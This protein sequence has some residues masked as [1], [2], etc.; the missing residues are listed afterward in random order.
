L[1]FVALLA[2][3]ELATDAGS[4]AVRLAYLA[5]LVVAGV[6]MID[7]IILERIRTIAFASLASFFLRVGTLTSASA[8]VTGAGVIGALFAVKMMT[9]FVGVRPTSTYFRL[10]KRER[11]Y[12][13]LLTATGLTFG[14]IAAL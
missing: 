13:T 11:T 10:P 2:L 12:T 1:I 6:F 8:L 7:R 9:K 3:G 4:E 14:S 5:G